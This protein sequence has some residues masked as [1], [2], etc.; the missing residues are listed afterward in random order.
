MSRVAVF[1][2]PPVMTVAS[3]VLLSLMMSGW[4]ETWSL[5]NITNLQEQ[6]IANTK[7]F[8]I[9]FDNIEEWQD[10]ESKVREWMAF[11]TQVS[12]TFDPD[13]A[14]IDTHVYLQYYVDLQGRHRCH[15]EHEVRVREIYYPSGPGKTSLDIKKSA[16]STRAALKIPIW[17]ASN[18]TSLQKVEHDIHECSEKYSRVSRV[19][20]DGTGWEFNRCRDISPYFPYLPEWD[21]KHRKNKVRSH[22][23][24]YWWLSSYS[25]YL[26]ET[27]LYKLSFTLRYE[28]LEEAQMS[29]MT[30]LQG[31]W[32]L[33]IYALG[34]G[35]SDL[36]DSTVVEDVNESW[37]KLIN[38]FGNGECKK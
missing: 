9:Q 10:R 4:Y 2:L 19:W 17:P 23:S 34:D 27:T 8:Q 21:Q 33:R 22:Q 36:W 38:Y 16:S 37:L 26:N 3:L 31:E 30:P 35:L 14:E 5:R 13:S 12:S 29:S 20:I 6:A 32:S 28:S 11:F 15:S 18:Y 25:G 24:Q 1:L 7:E